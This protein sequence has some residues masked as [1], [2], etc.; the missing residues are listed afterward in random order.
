MRLITLDTVDS[1]N[2]EA[3]R[4]IAAREVSHMDVLLAREQTAGRG[5]RG[6]AWVGTSGESMLVSVV[7]MGRDSW[8]LPTPTVLSMAVGLALI[9]AAEELGLAR[10]RVALDWPNDLIA[11][12]P[13]EPRG[14]GE[15]PKLAGILVETRAFDPEAPVFVVGVGAN[16]LQTDFPAEL[17]AERPVASL[18]QLGLP[19]EPESFARAFASALEG[20]LETAATAPSEV[21]A[22]YVDATA[23]GG[24][25]VELELSGGRPH[26]R[27]IFIEP[28]GVRLLDRDDVLL[29]F[30]LEH[31][32]AIRPV[33]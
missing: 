11:V 25:E 28:D 18:A 7:L 19:V 24:R 1:T 20:L 31:I 13:N 16:L 33:G 26:G 30:P 32:Q 27:L 22:D 2:E 12:D 3:F 15:A 5:R 4:R 10:G 29:S 9:D 21:C 14:P 8:S 23:L 17:L 6:A